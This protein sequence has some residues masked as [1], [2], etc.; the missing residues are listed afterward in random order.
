M[1]LEIPLILVRIFFPCMR[2]SLQVHITN[3][4][5][6]SAD[7]DAFAGEI[8]VTDFADSS[9][10]PGLHP[11]TMPAPVPPSS[12]GAH[13]GNS[14]KSSSGDVVGAVDGSGLSLSRAFQ[15]VAASL[16]ALVAAAAPCLEAQRSPNHFEYLGVDVMV[17]LALIILSC[18]HSFNR[19]F[20]TR[21]ALII[22]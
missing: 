15:D 5:A 16:A 11:D 12:R 8:V 1:L 9:P 6:N 21:L 4:C 19:C 22:S 20:L 17:R 7:K 3:C 14:T 10:F 18:H 13:E 2:A